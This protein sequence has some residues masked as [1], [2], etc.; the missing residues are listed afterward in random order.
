MSRMGNPSGGAFR[1]AVCPLVL[2]TVG[3][4]PG[5]GAYLADPAARRLLEFFEAKG[6]AAL[7]EEDRREQWYDDWLAYQ[8]G[9]G[10]YAAVLSPKAYSAAGREFDLLRYARF[11]EVFG[12]CS[13]AHG[14]SLQVTSLGLFAIM[15]GSN[16]DLK[17]E[18]VAAVEAGG[19]LAFAVSERD[20]GADLLGNAFTVRDAGPGRFV[21]G[22]SKFYIGNANSA[23]MIAV[24]AKKEGR[25]VA[26]A[27][28]AR[29]APMAVFALRPGRSPGFGNVRKIHT[30]GVRSGFVG[31]FDVAGHEFPESD[32]VADGRGAWDAVFAAITL[33]KFFLGFGSV[34]IC[35]HALAEA[36]AHLTSRILYG[37]PV[38][39]MPHI[40]SLAAQAYA[41]LA[42][43]KL[44]AYRAVDYARAATAADRRY[45]LFCAVQKAKVS[46]EGVRVM[47]L[48]SECVGAK[49][50]EAD[51]FFEMALRDAQLIPG[52]EGST[53]VNLA[54]AAQFIPRYFDHPDAALG[55]PGSLVAGG[56]PAGENEYLWEA[57]TGALHTVAFPPYL[58]A[59]R[60]LRHVPNV[61]TFAR[62][63][64]ALRLCLR[65]GRC[66]RALAAGTETALALGQCL[67]T[68]AYGQLIAENAARL[69]VAPALVSAVFHLLVNDLSGSALALASSPDLGPAGRALVRRVVAVPRTSRAD[70]DDVAGRVIAR[71]APPQPA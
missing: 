26:A 10:L 12:Y 37:K 34:G 20:H 5:A 24:L 35:E 65:A 3:P 32:V 11:L 45:V 42:A 27:G 14:Y 68:V 21:A 6:L 43:M 1:D 71:A 25:R 2:S 46:T 15:A 9:H 55:E 29:R 28:E 19:L 4:T 8:A 18:A 39:A 50:F 62:Q 23:A 36:A 49:G 33:G 40:R 17:R 22:G 52:L 66:K 58:R 31:A 63:A 70:W 51:T 30:L 53:H 64:K 67:A 44:Y 59:Y 16:P 69:G 48:L 60:P 57:R 38:L 61:R 56:Q 54:L 7:K 13:A 41:R 47:A